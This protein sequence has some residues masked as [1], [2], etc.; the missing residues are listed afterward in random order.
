MTIKSIRVLVRFDFPTKTM[1]IWDGSGPY[2]DAD[3]EIW[4]GATLNDG[5]DQIES[6]L[7]AEASTLTLSLSGIAPEIADL[8]Y[9]DLQAGNVIDSP[10]QILIQP[11]DQWDQPVGP[12][13]VRF[14]GAI[15]NMPMDDTVSGDQIVSTVMLE[16]R[17][18]FDLRTLTSGA[19]LSDVDQRAR[20]A[21]LN[22]GAPSDRFAERIPGLADK[23]IVWPRYS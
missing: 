17:N 7:N 13:E 1:R 5:L 23:T 4:S 9:F 11:C 20:S 16:V 12:A 14:T 6:A 3:G 21:V 8:A 18:R 2:M 22:P 10:V 19:V 15:D